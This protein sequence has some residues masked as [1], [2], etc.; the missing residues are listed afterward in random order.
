MA[1]MPLKMIIERVAKFV[2]KR[3]KMIKGAANNAAT[4]RGINVL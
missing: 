1:Q 2:V 4:H 3:G